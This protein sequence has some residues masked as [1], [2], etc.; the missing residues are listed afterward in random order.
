MEQIL[1][2]RP[3]STVEEFLFHEDIS[4]SKLNKK[5]LDVLV[6][7]GACDPISDARFKHCKHLWL[8]VASDRPKNKKKLD[9]NIIKYNSEPDFTEEERIENIVS[10]TGIFPFDIVMDKKVRERIEVNCVPPLAHVFFLKC[11]GEANINF[12]LLLRVDISYSSDS[13]INSLEL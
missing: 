4:Y 3:F 10:L 9:E 2:H 13:T 5:A 12:L 7:S 6:R 1:E 8:S 11:K